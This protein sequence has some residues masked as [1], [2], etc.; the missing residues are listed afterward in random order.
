[1]LPEPIQNLGLLGAAVR[2]EGYASERSD[3]LSFIDEHA[4][5]N[6]VFIAADIHGII[7][8]GLTYQRRGDV[9]KALATTGNP[10]T[11]PHHATSAFEI[12]TG[13]V[14]FDPAF[15]D[16]VTQLLGLVPGG[17]IILDQLLAS[18]QASSLDEFKKLPMA[19]KN[20]A[21]QKLI[22]QQ[23]SSLGYTQIGLQDNK[24]IKAKLK[25][26][27]NTALYSFGWSKFDIKPGNHS[28]K[29]TTYGIEAYTSES[30]ANN[31]AEVINRKPQIVSEIIISPQL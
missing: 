9:L 13:A 11:A 17:Q 24:L 3:L 10:L 8:N 25:Q 1:M 21:L 31:S 26:G 5:K 12:T 30:L 15:G 6:V 28:L 20:V 29:T 14:A 18:V 16:A 22:D 7:I 4:I 19:T 23:L 27:S 2:Y